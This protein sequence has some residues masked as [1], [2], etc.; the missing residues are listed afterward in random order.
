MP[1][2][3]MPGNSF[4]GCLRVMKNKGKSEE[5]AKKICG[6]IKSETEDKKKPSYFSH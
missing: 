6:K 2:P 3:K 4:Y 5:S 1:N